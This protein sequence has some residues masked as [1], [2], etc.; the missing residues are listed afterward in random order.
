MIETI[1][2]IIAA[3]VLIA[4]YQVLSKHFTAKLLAATTLVAIAFIYV[5]FSLKENPVHFIV[6]EVGFALA[7]YFIAIIGYARNNMLL[8]FGILLHGVWDIFHHKGIPIQT[9]VPGYWPTFC[10]LIDIIDGLYFVFVFKTKKADK[11][12]LVQAPESHFQKAPVRL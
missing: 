9:D 3:F 12:Y 4:V 11:Q 7:L 8:A 6:L 1:S 10:F 2:G 5:G